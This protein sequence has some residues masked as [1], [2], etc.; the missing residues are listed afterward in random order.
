MVFDG[1]DVEAKGGADD[2]GVL[3]IDLQHNRC[4][5]RIIQ[6]PE[7]ITSLTHGKAKKNHEREPRTR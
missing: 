2:T 4:L 1:L 6:A 5:T 3:S 7:S